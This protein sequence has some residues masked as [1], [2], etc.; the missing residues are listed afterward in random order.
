M[1]FKNFRNMQITAADGDSPVNTHNFTFDGDFSVD[2]PAEVVNILTDRGELPASPELV[3]GEEQPMTGSWVVKPESMSGIA[4]EIAL[5][6]LPTGWVSTTDNADT[7]DIIVTD[8]TDTQ[9]YPD[10]IVRGSWSEGGEGGVSQELS[11]TFTCPH[12]RPTLS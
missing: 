2:V 5:K 10:S 3:P 7:I 1:A 11:F 4:A 8:G 12:N 9:T 6:G